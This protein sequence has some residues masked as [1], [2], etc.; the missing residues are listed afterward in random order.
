MPALVV[1]I[2]AFLTSD[3]ELAASPSYDPNPCGNDSQGKPL[4]GCIAVFAAKHNDAKA[5]RGRRERRT[6][7]DPAPKISCAEGLGMR[8]P[9][10]ARRNRGASIRAIQE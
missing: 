7:I 1:G 2:D 3:D 5:G 6:A 10:A 4:N 9:R 8:L